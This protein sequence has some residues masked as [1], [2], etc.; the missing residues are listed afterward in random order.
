MLWTSTQYLT[1]LSSALDKMTVV[2][3]VNGDAVLNNVLQVSDHSLQMFL[4]CLNLLLATSNSDNIRIIPTCLGWEHDT[5]SK[6]L[7]Y[8]KMEKYILCT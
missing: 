2:T 6:L 4:G 1:H 3:R 5:R 7:S 8:L